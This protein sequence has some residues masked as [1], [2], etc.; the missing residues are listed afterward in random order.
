M[1]DAPPS[2]T[3]KMLSNARPASIHADSNVVLLEDAGKRITREL[4]AWSILKISGEQ[5]ARNECSWQSTQN[6]VSSELNNQQRTRGSGF[7]S[8]LAI[9]TRATISLITTG[10]GMCFVLKFILPQS[11]SEYRCVSPAIYQKYYGYF[12]ELEKVLEVLLEHYK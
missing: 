10:T 8:G 5:H 1:L 2:R 9:E 7:K 12:C 6:S 11:I 4:A 3:T